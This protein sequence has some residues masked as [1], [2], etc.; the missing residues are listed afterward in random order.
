MTTNSKGSLAVMAVTVPCDEGYSSPF[1]SVAY[2]DSIGR[3]KMQKDKRDLLEVWKNAPGGGGAKSSR[4]RTY[5][6]GNNEFRKLSLVALALLEAL[7]P[8]VDRRPVPAPLNRKVRRQPPHSRPR[9]PAT[10]SGRSRN[11]SPERF[12]AGSCITENQCCRSGS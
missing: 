1:G 9:P 11:P 10:S 8:G 7:S 3:P 5:I 4:G 2:F 6:M 12:L